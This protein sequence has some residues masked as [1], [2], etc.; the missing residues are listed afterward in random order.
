MINKL[1]KYSLRKQL[2]TKR[3]ELSPEFIL[4]NSKKIEAYLINLDIYQKTT[5]IMVYVATQD[6][7]QTQEI[8]KSAQKDKKKYFHTSNHQEKQNFAPFFSN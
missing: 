7:V 3:R 4:E 1:D 6:E 5:N 2:L 8:I